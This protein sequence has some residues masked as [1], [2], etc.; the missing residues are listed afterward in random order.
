MSNLL[1]YCKTDIERRYVKAYINS[2]ENM[3]IA[4]QSVDKNRSTVGDIVRRVKGREAS[5]ERGEHAQGVPEGYKIKGVSTLYN[6][7]GD[8]SAQWVKTDRD[9]ER[10][11]E[12]VEKAVASLATQL[13][14]L[15]VVKPPKQVNKDLCTLYTF[16]DY[17]LGMLAWD[18]EAGDDWDM[19]IAE[20]TMF[21]ALSQMITGSPDSEDAIFNLQGD[22]EHW[23]SLTPITPTSGHVLDADSRFDKLVELSIKIAIQCVELLLKKHKKVRVLICEGNH[24]MTSS[25]WLRKCLKAVFTKNK[26]IEVDD[27]AFPYYAYLHGEIMLAFHHG[28]KKKNKDLPALFSSEPRYR[29]MWGQAKYTYIHTGHY[30]HAE[31]DMAEAGGAIVERHPTLAARDA[32][33]ARGGYVSLRAARAI[34]YHKGKGE[35]CRIT[36]VP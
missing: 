2:G 27:T 25:V 32:H 12:A 21:K 3:T 36:V 18:Q 17:H 11:L 30:H 14:K 8:V 4:A 31:Q 22:W 35:H 29:E 15:Q 28:H 26:R 6:G 7:D 20:E 1:E 19:D 24:N 16:T 10:Q 34:T 23:D 13:P 33:A 9:T 5:K